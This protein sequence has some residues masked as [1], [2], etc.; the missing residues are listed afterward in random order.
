MA[1]QESSLEFRQ[2]MCVSYELGS[3]AGV[4]FVSDIVGVVYIDLGSNRAVVNRQG[5]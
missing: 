4:V 3:A 2:R 1:R 5:Q